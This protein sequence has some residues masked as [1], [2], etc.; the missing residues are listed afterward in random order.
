MRV[1]LLL[2]QL[3]GLFELRQ[4]AVEHVGGGGHRR[5]GGQQG[6]DGRPLLRLVLAHSDTLLQVERRVN[7]CAHTLNIIQECCCSKVKNERV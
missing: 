3:S 6:G 5:L 1:V 2:V 4:L 7:L